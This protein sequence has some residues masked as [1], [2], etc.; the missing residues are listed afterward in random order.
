[1][2]LKRWQKL[3]LTVLG[4]GAV[5]YGMV[6]ADVVLRAREAWIQGETYWRWADH[7]EERAAYLQGQEAVEQAALTKKKTQGTLSA[8]DYDRETELLKFRYEQMGKESCV[9]YAY[10]WYQTAVQLFSPPE[11]KWV[12]LSRVKMPLAKERWKAEL[13]AHH[14]PYEDYMLD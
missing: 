13:N 12:K 8:D 2:N 4:I 14:I 5:F 1:L 3:A 10:V 11:S 9:K 6:Y 7:P